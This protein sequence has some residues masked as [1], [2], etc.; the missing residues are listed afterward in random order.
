MRKSIATFSALAALA[1]AGMTAGPAAADDPNVS[2]FQGGTL[3][4]S[5]HT[6]CQ[7]QFKSGV[8]GQYGAS[9]YF[10]DGCTVTRGCPATH[11]GRAVALLRRQQRVRGSPPRSRAA[12]TSP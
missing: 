9:G 7:T 2:Y 6:S 3:G 12:T 4:G 11:I 1:L 5:N 8:L 10:L